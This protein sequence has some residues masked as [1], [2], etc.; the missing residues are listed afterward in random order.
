MLKGAYDAKGEEEDF[1]DDAFLKLSE[2]YKERRLMLVAEPQ[3]C[4]YYSQLH[5]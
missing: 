5:V 1:D 3:V 4:D 2:S